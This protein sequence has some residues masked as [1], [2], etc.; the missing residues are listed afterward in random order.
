MNEV[1]I[2]TVFESAGQPDQQHIQLWVDTALDD[3]GRDAEIVVRIVD[4]QESTELNEQYRH[5]QGPTNILS[6]PVDVPEGIDLNLLG[7]LVICAPVLENE[8][9]EQNKCLADHWAHIVVHGVLHLLGYDHID[10]KEA[11]LMENKEIEILNK[12]KI[13]NPYTEVNDK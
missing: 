4:E 11:E 7:D 5:K 12:L 1:E 3:Y 13:N 8:A 10:D 6:F 2:Q 9:L